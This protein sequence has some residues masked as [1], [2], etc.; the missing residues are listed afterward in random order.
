MICGWINWGLG[1]IVG[2]VLAKAI[3]VEFYPYS[4]S[5]AL[6]GGDGEEKF[7]RL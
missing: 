3:G 1:L 6:Q 4:E 5:L 7:I 2:A